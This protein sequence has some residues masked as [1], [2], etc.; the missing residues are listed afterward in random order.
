MLF[1]TPPKGRAEIKKRYGDF[2]YTEMSGGNIHI[3]GTWERDNLVLLRNVCE[4]GLKIQLHRLVAP[5]FEECLADAIKRCPDYHIRQLGGF[6]ARH[7]MHDPTRALSIH[8]WGAAFDINWG[9]NP[10]GPKLITDLPIEFISA[11]TLKGWEWGGNW[12][13]TIDSMH[14]QFGSM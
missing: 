5:I 7:M 4:T 11:F 13:G 14:Y 8:S 6:C 12:Q 10:V 9:T 3:D 2:V 1:H